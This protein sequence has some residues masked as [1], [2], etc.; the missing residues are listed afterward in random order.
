M[1]L[2]PCFPALRFALIVIFAALVSFISFGC[3]ASPQGGRFAG[4][5]GFG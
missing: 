2:R 1:D 3:P 4:L 5:A